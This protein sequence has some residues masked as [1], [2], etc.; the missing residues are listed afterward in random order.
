MLHR[1]N[2]CIEIGYPLLALLRDAKVAQGITDI[3]SYR[4]PEESY[5]LSG[6]PSKP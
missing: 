2:I 5:A 1:K 4:L 3:W 6:S